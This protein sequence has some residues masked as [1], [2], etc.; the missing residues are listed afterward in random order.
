M[1][2]SGAE[3]QRSIHSFTIN[4][5]KWGHRRS[6]T[7]WNLPPIWELFL[8]DV[9]VPPFRNVLL[10]VWRKTRIFFNHVMA[11]PPFLP[12]RCSFTSC[13]TIILWSHIGGCLFMKRWSC[14]GWNFQTL[15]QFLFACLRSELEQ[16]SFHLLGTKHWR[17]ASKLV[18]HR[19]WRKMSWSHENWSEE[20][21]NH[22]KKQIRSTQETQER[23]AQRYTERLCVLF[24]IW[25]SSQFFWEHRSASRG[26]CSRTGWMRANAIGNRCEGSRQVMAGG[27][28]RGCWLFRTPD[29][30]WICR[31]GCPG[32]AVWHLHAAAAQKA[33]SCSEHQKW[34]IGERQS[35]AAEANNRTRWGGLSAAPLALPSSS[36]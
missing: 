20:L 11:A 16:G 18:W 35:A 25:C 12:L 22:S 30:V 2:H 4:V 29:D 1:S 19:S 28:R 17:E 14:A 8:Y 3:D 36:R 32:T 34:I 13:E 26:R 10:E 24:I 5:C 7:L 9:N 21:H 6:P 31:P 33:N 23:R 15:E 27:D